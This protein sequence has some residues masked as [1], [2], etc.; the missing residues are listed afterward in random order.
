MRAS[1]LNVLVIHGKTHPPSYY[2]C[3]ENK[4]TGTIEPNNYHKELFFI[5]RSV[6]NS[7]NK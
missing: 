4:S 5:K 3:E 2:L 6:I 1:G 7:A